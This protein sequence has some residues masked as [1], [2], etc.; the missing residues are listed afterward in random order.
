MAMYAALNDV[1]VVE[2]TVTIPWFGIWTADVKIDVPTLINGHA[3]GLAL[4]LGN[5]TMIGTKFRALAFQ[6]AKKLR[7]V[8]GYGG[9][10]KMLPSAYYA[11]ES[12][13][14]RSLILRDA[15]KACGESVSYDT[16]VIVGNSY[17]RAAGPASRVLNQLARSGWYMS[18]DGITTVGSRSTDTITT[19][20]QVLSADG[21]TGHYQIATEDVAAYMP[22][23]SF[24]LPDDGTRQI[25][26]TEIQLRE[27][28]IR[29]SVLAP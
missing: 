15:A 10:L 14:K 6:G 11:Q 19:P 22:G 16:D 5:V 17:M 27:N 24:Q 26:A 2:A 13:L 9:W 25:S 12:G 1:H 28:T 7:I 23:R 3:G 18:L 20:L 4:T 21:A 29:V 8:G